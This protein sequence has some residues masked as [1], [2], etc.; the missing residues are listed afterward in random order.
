MIANTIDYES[1]FYSFWLHRYNLPGLLVF[2]HF[3][4]HRLRVLL[5]KVTYLLVSFLT[6]FKNKKQRIRKQWICFTI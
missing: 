1:D 4:I 2:S 3:L 5:N 6:A